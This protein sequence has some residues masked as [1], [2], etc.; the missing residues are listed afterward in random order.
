MR[1]VRTDPEI[2]GHA[3]VDG[4]NEFVRAVLVPRCPALA[5]LWYGPNAEE[6]DRLK[7]EVAAAMAA[8]WA[9]APFNEKG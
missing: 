7:Y 4:I 8:K 5:E 1:E 9:V 6:L 2:V 3:I